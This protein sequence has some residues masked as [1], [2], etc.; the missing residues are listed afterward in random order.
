MRDSRNALF[1]TLDP[2]VQGSRVS[3]CITVP[4][5]YQLRLLYLLRKHW[6]HVVLFL[7]RFNTYVVILPAPQRGLQNALDFGIHLRAF[8]AGIYLEF[9]VLF[10]TQSWTI[11]V[12][13]IKESCTRRQTDQ[14]SAFT[15]HYSFQTL[16]ILNLNSLLIWSSRTAGA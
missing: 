14:I 6:R 12:V 5:I 7:K 8:L 1:H 3:R 9:Q 4:F 11:I 15:D 13:I 2:A 16:I 10:R